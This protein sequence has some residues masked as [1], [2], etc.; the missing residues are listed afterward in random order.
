[1]LAIVWALALCGIATAQERGWALSA[2]W[3]PDGETIA[4]GSSTGIWLF[5]TGFND[6]FRCSL[7]NIIRDDMSFSPSTM[8]MERSGD[9]SDS[10]FSNVMYAPII[11]GSYSMEVVTQI[12]I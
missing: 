11:F 4:V 3:S 6:F 1:M 8:D 12:E 7:R 2:V 9:Q 10:W 5:D